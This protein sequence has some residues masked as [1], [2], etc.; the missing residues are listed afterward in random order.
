MAIPITPTVSTTIATPPLTASPP[1]T[2]VDV[3]VVSTPP[4]IEQLL[5]QIS[6]GG[7]LTTTPDNATATLS[8]ALGNFVF[9]FSQLPDATKQQLVQQLLSILQGQKNVT[10]V[11]QPGDPPTQAT[12]LL[13]N[14]PATASPAQTT[15]T[16]QPASPAT[17]PPAI[18]LSPGATLLA[19][20]L[21]NDIVIPG[22]AATAPNAASTAQA[23]PTAVALPPN[24]PVAQNTTIASSSALSETNTPTGASQTQAPAQ[25]NNPVGPTPTPSLQ[26]AAQIPTQTSV[27]QNVPLPNTPAPVTS[28]LVPFPPGKEVVIHIDAIALPSTPTPTPTAQNQVAAT[29]IGNGSNGQ[30]IVKTND[31]VFYVRTNADA[32]VG[33]NLLVTIDAPKP[34]T[35]TVLPPVEQQSF[36]ALQQTIDTLAQINPQLAQQ[37]IDN[38]IPQ[39]TPQLAGPLL[40]F[41]NVL[42]QG[43][44]KGWLG[45]DVS[46]TLT[47]SGKLQLIAKLTQ[48]LNS[49]AETTRDQAVGEWKSYTVPLLNNGQFQNMKLHV[50]ADQQG[51]SQKEEANKAKQVRFVIDVRMS[52]LGAMQLDGLVRPKKLDMILRSETS[53]PPGLPQDLRKSYIDMISALGFAGSLSFQLGKQGWVEPR[54]ETQQSVVL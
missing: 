3:S 29:V 15:T 30:L 17:L 41:L 22:T 45:K 51:Q 6:I 46:E 16:Q 37:F 47:K 53:L 26:T 33:T 39:P 5:R 34:T 40:F 36:T 43:D 20:T 52:Q 9:S 49:S 31:A 25:T 21:P 13:P 42:K 4:N 27:T 23:A 35:P 12:L 32:P 14:A 19:V 7:T 50:H 1:I 8:T 24:A 38:H 44:V 48:E 28:N 11:I 54:K 18:T 2:T 10:A